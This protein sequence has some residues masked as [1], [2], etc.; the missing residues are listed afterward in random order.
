MA[1]PVLSSPLQEYMDIYCKKSC[2]ESC[3]ECR[4]QNEHC[5]AWGDLKYCTN[6]KW[7]AYMVLRCKETCGVC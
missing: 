6:A 5:K 2:D 7:K 1:V 4:D 3:N